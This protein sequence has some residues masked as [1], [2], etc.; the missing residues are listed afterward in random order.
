MT[1]LPSMWP[2]RFGNTWS[3]MLTPA[4]PIAIRRSVISVGV[5]GIAAAGVDVGHHGNRD[6]ADDVPGE[7]EDVLHIDQADVG[8]GQQAAGQAEAAHLDGFEAG[9]SMILALSASWQPGTTKA[10]RCCSFSLST[11]ARFSPI[12]EKIPGQLF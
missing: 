8:L 5:D 1:C 12:E 9:A 6:R 11:A 2:Q 4:T 3:S 7:V 10:R